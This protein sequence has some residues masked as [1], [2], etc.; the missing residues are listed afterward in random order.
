MRRNDGV[1]AIL[2]HAARSGNQRRIGPLDAVEKF[3]SGGQLATFVGK[4]KGGR[5]HKIGLSPHTLD[6]VRIE[7]RIFADHRKL[8]RQALRDDEP[9]E[10][11]SVMK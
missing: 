3:P 10:W 11:I 9:V 5:R 8:I 2:T 4:R 6:T 1:A 7:D